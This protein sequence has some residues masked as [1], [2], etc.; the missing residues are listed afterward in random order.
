MEEVGAAPAAAPLRAPPVWPLYL[1]RKACVRVQSSRLTREYRGI[2]E[3]LQRYPWSWQG[4]A[5]HPRPAPPLLPICVEASEGRQVRQD[6]LRVN[7]ARQ[8]AFRPVRTLEPAAPPP[9]E[10]RAT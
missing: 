9:A 2:E 7:P 4:A 5:M 1:G 8:Y 3:A 10:E 6:A